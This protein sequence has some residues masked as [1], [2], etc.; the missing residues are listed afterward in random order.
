MSALLKLPHGKEGREG[1]EQ[2]QE[3]GGRANSAIVVGDNASVMGNDGNVVN[4]ANVVP[5]VQVTAV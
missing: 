3:K 2:P 5:D 1:R 4:V